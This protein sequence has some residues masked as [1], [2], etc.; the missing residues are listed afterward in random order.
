MSSL[1][2]N[3]KVRG[4][5]SLAM[6]VFD[7]QKEAWV[8]LSQI[9]EVIEESGL[10]GDEVTAI[11]VPDWVAAEKGLQQLQQDDDTLDLFGGDV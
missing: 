3:V 1:K 2:I 6:L 7:G 9:Q 10:F 5:T 11:V 4:R 8:P